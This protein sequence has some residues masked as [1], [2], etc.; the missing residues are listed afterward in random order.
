[1]ESALKIV[2]PERIVKLDLGCGQTC[3]EGFEGVD[4][5]E[6]NAKHKVNLMRFPWPFEDN[7]IEELYCSHFIEHLPLRDLTTTDIEL[8]VKTMNRFNGKDFLFAFFD[9]CYRILKPDCTM[10]VITP[11]A[12]SA[13]AFQDP[14][15]R[16]FIV[17][18]TFCYL[19]LNWRKTHKL[20]HYNVECN[21]DGTVNPLVPE[22]LN[23]LHPE[24]AQ[25]R[26]R[27]NVNTVIGWQAVMKAIK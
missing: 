27:E 23:L 25:R 3:K 13:G 26:F 14:T 4:L 21:F 24:A 17:A 10:T 1:M 8:N 20:D 2:Q 12:F 9:E 7:S 18:E 6:Q 5:Y 11:N 15:H 22:E 16:R 19:S